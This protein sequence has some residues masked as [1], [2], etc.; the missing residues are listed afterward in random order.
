MRRVRS[1]D[2]QLRRGSPQG[3]YRGFQVELWI[4]SFGPHD[5]AAVNSDYNTLEVRIVGGEELPHQTLA[6]TQTFQATGFHKRGSRG[7]RRD[8]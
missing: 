4:L 6:V 1:R 7:F 3:Q 8:L 5:P 2:T